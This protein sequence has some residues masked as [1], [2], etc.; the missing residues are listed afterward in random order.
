MRRTASLPQSFDMDT[1]NMKATTEHM[2]P[3]TGRDLV[4]GLVPDNA[5]TKTKILY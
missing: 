3:Q 1:I 4:Y 2:R 5:I